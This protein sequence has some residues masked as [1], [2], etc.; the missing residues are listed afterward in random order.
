MIQIFSGRNFRQQIPNISE[1]YMIRG[2]EFSVLYEMA[3]KFLPDYY[4]LGRD[5]MLSVRFE[6]FTLT[7]PP[8]PGDLSEYELR[9]FGRMLPHLYIAE[10]WDINM[11]SGSR[12]LIEGF[13][14]GMRECFENA[15]QKA[16][17]AYIG[18]YSG[19]NDMNM[20]SL[21]AEPSL[22]A[23]ELIDYNID[24]EENIPLSNINQY[25]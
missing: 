16:P 15:P 7:L 24:G 13:C 6:D 10:R 18:F 22:V 23:E 20:L 25:F 4:E 8:L 14:E 11:Y 21:S 1:Q 5:W 3:R 9:Q 19:N 17:Q 12:S 2:H